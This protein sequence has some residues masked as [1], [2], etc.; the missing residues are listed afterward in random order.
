MT[1][2]AP[3]EADGKQSESGQQQQQQQQQQRQGTAWTKPAA[4]RKEIVLRAKQSRAKKNT[5]KQEEKKL[6]L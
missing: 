3:S 1:D 4:G 2:P 5:R 6:T